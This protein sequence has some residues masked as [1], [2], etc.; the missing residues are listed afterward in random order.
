MRVGINMSC[1]LIVFTVWMVLFQSLFHFPKRVRVCIQRKVCA[2]VNTDFTQRSVESY[3]TQDP[4]RWRRQLDS[5]C[6]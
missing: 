2:Y 4:V 3:P 1:M 6:V 5:G